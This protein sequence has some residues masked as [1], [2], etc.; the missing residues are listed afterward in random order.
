MMSYTMTMEPPKGF[1]PAQ[2]ELLNMVACL[3]GDEDCLALKRVLVEFL[4]QRL[5]GALDRLYDSGELSD[6]KM[7]EISHCHLRTAYRNKV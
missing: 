4:D 7:E 5:Q 3:N 1:S 6:A 2:Y